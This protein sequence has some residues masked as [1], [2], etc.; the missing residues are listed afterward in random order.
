MA[1][2]AFAP[3]KKKVSK[4]FLDSMLSLR[5]ISAIILCMWMKVLYVQCSLP[6]EGY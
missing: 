2:G 5:F 1:L 4:L 6:S 3:L